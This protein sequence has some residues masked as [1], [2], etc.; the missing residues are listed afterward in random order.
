M[1]IRLFTMADL[2][3]ELGLLLAADD[4]RVLSLE[5]LRHWRSS[6][7]AAAQ[8]LNLVAVD[9]GRVIGVAG[10]GRN[11]WTSTP[12]AGGGFVTVTADRRREGIG[13][14]LWEQ[15]AAHLAA[16]GVER[17]TTFMRQTDEGERFATSRGFERVIV[18]PLIALDPRTVS[19][20][21]IP[22][23]LRCI[24]LSALTPADVYEAMCEAALDEPSV[25]PNDAIPLVE[26]EREWNDPLFDTASSAAVVD[27]GDVVAFA[28]M[29]V[30][31]DR[32][33]HGFTGCK[34]S[35]RGRGLA[36][37]AKRAALRAAAAR[38]VVRVTTSNAEENAA[39]RA[40]NS[41]LGFEPIGEHLILG[42]SL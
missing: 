7:P 42:R 1:E 12:N 41:R 19:A 32:G 31:E 29:K 5:S 30:A 25:E 10:G 21:V 23:G 16:I 24:A 11:I 3:A 15:V 37:V 20:P 38:G 33:Q 18:G 8:N 13:A 36:T 40:I 28:F 26:F 22:A 39:M 27:D 17:V 6:Q 2:E 14:A 35:H 34:R 4:A 9:E